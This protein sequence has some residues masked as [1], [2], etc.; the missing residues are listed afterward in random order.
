MTEHE[1]FTNLMAR[2]ELQKELYQIEVDRLRN[3]GYPDHIIYGEN[4]SNDPFDDLNL[5]KLYL[6]DLKNK[7][8]IIGTDIHNEKIRLVRDHIVDK[9]LIKI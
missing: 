8:E 2:R 3:K 1:I 4:L 6:I 7:Q 5:L 9:F